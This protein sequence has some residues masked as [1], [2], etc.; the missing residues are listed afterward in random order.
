MHVEIAGI[1]SENAWILRPSEWP[2]DQV[3]MGFAFFF[4]PFHVF[5]PLISSSKIY[6]QVPRL[7]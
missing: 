7:L 6:V 2:V 5:V 4:Q 3:M 1:C